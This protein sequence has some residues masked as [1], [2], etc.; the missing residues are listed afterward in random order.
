MAPNL[1]S[2]VTKAIEAMKV[3]GYSEKVVKPV[4]RNLLNLYNKNWKL[5]EDENYSVLLESIIDS[6][7][8]KVLLVCYY[9]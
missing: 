3:F 8:S 1:N 9:L 2:R 5:I 7:E 6:E 4:L